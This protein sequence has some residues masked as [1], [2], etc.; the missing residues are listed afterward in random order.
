MLTGASGAQAPADWKVRP[1]LF[2]W[3]G[4]T[5]NWEDPVRQAE[6]EGCPSAAQTPLLASAACPCCWEWLLCSR[7]ENCLGPSRNQL[8]GC[9]LPAQWRQQLT[10]LDLKSRLPRAPELLVGC[11]SRYTLVETTSWFPSFPTL[12]ASLAALFQTAPPQ[13]IVRLKIQVS[14]LIWGNPT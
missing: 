12:P 11:G 14:G 1:A 2:P 6:G 8:A 4:S 9:V 7:P 13:L 5:G 10:D 3:E